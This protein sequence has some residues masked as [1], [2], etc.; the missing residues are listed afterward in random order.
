VMVGPG[1]LLS[2]ERD[3]DWRKRMKIRTLVAVLFVI[4]VIWMPCLA[5]EMADNVRVV[6]VMTAAINDRDF[7]ALDSLIAA[8]L[9][10]H[11][12]ST[13]GVK[14]SSLEEFKEFLR[15]DL[16]ACPD[17]KQEI[18]IIFGSGDMVAVRATYRGTQTG[19]MGPFPPSGKRME[20]P[21]IG[22]LRLEHGKVAEIWVE[23]DNMSALSQLGHF[24][25]P[26]TEKKSE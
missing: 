24:P 21:F 16:A 7:A 3:D 22:I 18:D 19:Q 13:P 8:N 9:V 6:E 2:S 25:P 4:A 11:S 23:W 17:A 5:T 14:V 12:N 26:G 1:K 10:R 20:L 15:A